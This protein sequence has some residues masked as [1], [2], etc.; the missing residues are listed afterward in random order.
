MYLRKN[1]FHTTNIDKELDEYERTLDDLKKY[2][3]KSKE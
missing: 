1:R 3:K 2:R